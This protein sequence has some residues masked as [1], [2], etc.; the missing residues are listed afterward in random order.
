MDT[1]IYT[2]FDHLPAKVKVIAFILDGM[3]HK[4]TGV[5]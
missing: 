1:R 2:L 4:N 5:L 3:L